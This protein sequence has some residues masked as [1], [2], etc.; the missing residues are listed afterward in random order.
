MW[1]SCTVV[2]TLGINGQIYNFKTSTTGNMIITIYRNYYEVIFNFYYQI[3]SL[4]LTTD[5]FFIY[6]NK[7]IALFSMRRYGLLTSYYFKQY[8]I[9]G[10]FFLYYVRKSTN[11]HFCINDI[12]PLSAQFCSVAHLQFMNIY[13]FC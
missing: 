3:S 13:Y 10:K 5:I 7:I 9:L 2:V 1:C 11:K 6:Q 4:L 8:G 12:F